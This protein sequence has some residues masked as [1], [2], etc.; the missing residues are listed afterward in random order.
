MESIWSLVVT[1]WLLVVT[2]LKDFYA[3]YWIEDTVVMTAVMIAGC[4]HLIRIIIHLGWDKYCYSW[5]RWKW[6]Y[7][8]ILSPR[9]SYLVL[10]TQ[11]LLFYV[12]TYYRMIN[13]Y[14]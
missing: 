2:V 10:I 13:L 11:A 3:K 7:D 4:Y 9:Y 6:L 12:W 14:N 5:N 8:A 1:V